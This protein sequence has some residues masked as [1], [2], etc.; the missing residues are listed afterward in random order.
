M[1]YDPIPQI[2]IVKASFPEEITLS[3]GTL[4]RNVVHYPNNTASECGKFVKVMQLSI[5][6]HYKKHKGIGWETDKLTEMQEDGLIYVY[7]TDSNNEVIAFLSFVLTYEEGLV[8]YLYEIQIIPD[9]HK[10]GL[11]KILIDAFHDNIRNYREDLKIKGLDIDELE[12]SKLTVF[13][14]NRVLNWYLKLGYELAQESPI[15]KKL[16]NGK[17]IK[18]DYYI[19]FKKL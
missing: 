5:D 7:Y 2:P 10:L 13:T 15:D 4:S 1:N 14:D 18:P 12:G 6:G 8:L 3:K 17:V 9:W 16:R 11:G 19:L